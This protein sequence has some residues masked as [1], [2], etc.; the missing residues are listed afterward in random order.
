MAKLHGLCTLQAPGRERWVGD[1][2]GAEVPGE[3]DPKDSPMC[4]GEGFK[5]RE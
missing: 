4:K 3:Q 5:S 1:C 2:F